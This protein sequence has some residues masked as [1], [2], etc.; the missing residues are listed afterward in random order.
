MYDIS[1]AE[2]TN[3]DIGKQHVDIIK[4][5]AKISICLRKKIL[6]AAN[7]LN[8]SERYIYKLIRNHRESHGILTSLIP[9]KPSG[10]K[11]KL[12][13]SQHQETLIEQVIDKFNRASN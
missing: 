11:G 5:L 6:E 2:G 12:R 10:G 8:L 9:Q 3:L 4:P 7:T 1:K 13:L